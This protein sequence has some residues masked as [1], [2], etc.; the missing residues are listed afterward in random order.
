MKAFVP[1]RRETIFVARLSDITIEANV[2]SGHKRLDCVRRKARTNPVARLF[3]ERVR[4]SLP[5]RQLC[6]KMWL[7]LIG[8]IEKTI[9]I[10]SLTRD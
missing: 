6:A 5:E 8:C 9:G 3:T 7:R 10:V 4:P 1:G 2:Q